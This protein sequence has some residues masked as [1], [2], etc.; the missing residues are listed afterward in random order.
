MWFLFTF[1]STRS[2]VNALTYIKF[3]FVFRKKA[4]LMCKK[5]PHL[6]T[7]TNKKTLN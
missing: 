7:D 6:Y 5:G 2:H 4:I 3:S 1:T